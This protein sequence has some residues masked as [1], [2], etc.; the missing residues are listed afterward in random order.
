L[1]SKLG[2]NI[3]IILD[4]P[5]RHHT[6]RVTTERK[7]NAERARLN[8]IDLQA[9]LARAMQLEQRPPDEFIQSINSRLQTNLKQRSNRLPSDFSSVLKDLVPR[10]PKPLP[11][12]PTSA[13]R[14]ITYHTKAW[15]RRE[16]CDRF[17]IGRNHK[18]TDLR[19]CTLHRMN[20]RV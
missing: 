10:I 9:K 18:S 19:Y 1:L 20:L 14:Q 5:T 13:K 3:N 15:K 6:K 12:N 11:A 4:P 17:G 2:A 16:Y 8:C 7:G